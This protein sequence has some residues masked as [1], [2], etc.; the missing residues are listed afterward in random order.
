M[1]RIDVTLHVTREGQ[2]ITVHGNLGVRL[3][4]EDSRVSEV[5]ITEDA[6]HVEYFHS[7]LGQLLEAA[8]AERSG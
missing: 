5:G 3:R 4:I 1:G 2:K 7:Q 8:K 6:Q